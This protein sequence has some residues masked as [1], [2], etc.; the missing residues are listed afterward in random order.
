MN[1]ESE[2]IRVDKFLWAVRVFKTRSLATDACRKGK[3]IIDEI[4]VKPSRVVKEDDVIH[5]KR[6]P[7]VYSYRVKKLLGKRL[8]AKLVVDYVE[9]ITPEEELKKLEV[10]ETFFIKRDRGSG[11]PTK[12][13][14]RIID[15]LNRER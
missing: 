3:V 1:R 4:Q 8:S 7:V 6:N 10:K 14:R 5:V 2:E 12:K 9:N 15:K 13:E 11:R